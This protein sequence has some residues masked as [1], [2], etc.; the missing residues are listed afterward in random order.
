MGMPVGGNSESCVSVANRGTVS[1]VHD[2]LTAS[3]LH[4]MFTDYVPT[5]QETQTSTV[6]PV[7]GN[8]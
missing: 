8:T 3:S 6:N 5:A 4:V 1:A 7:L 2:V